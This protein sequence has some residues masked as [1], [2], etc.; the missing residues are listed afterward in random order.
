MKTERISER[1]LD[2]IGN[3]GSGIS[4]FKTYAKEEFG[5]FKEGARITGQ[6]LFGG[7][8]SD[9]AYAS[10]QVDYVDMAKAPGYSQ[11]VLYFGKKSGGR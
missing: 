11:N 6:K 4:N 3:V 1:Y 9:P 7:P 10:A 5:T 8:Y 2:L